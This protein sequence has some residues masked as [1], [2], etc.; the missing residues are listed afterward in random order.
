[1][2][3]VVDSFFIVVSIVL[4]GIMVNP[5]FVVHFLVDSFAIISLGTKVNWSLYLNY[6][7]VSFDS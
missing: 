2:S 4:W 6:L 1:M 3:V 5:C 7:L